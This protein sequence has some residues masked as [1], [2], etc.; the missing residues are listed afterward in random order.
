MIMLNPLSK[1]I[2]SLEFKISSM[3]KLTISN[4][5]RKS[6]GLGIRKRMIYLGT[7]LKP[8]E[9]SNGL[10]FPLTFKIDVESNAEKD[11]TII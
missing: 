8:K 11:G 10:T 3:K 5:T 4:S 7:W 2:S 6:K 9:P 1:K